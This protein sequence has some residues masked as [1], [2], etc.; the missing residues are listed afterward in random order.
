MAGKNQHKKKN[1]I[2]YETDKIILRELAVA[3]IETKKKQHDK[4]LPRNYAT[5]IL[6]KYAP[7]HPWLNKKLIFNNIAAAENIEKSNVSV[8]L[9]NHMIEKLLFPLHPPRSRN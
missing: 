3:D 5:N 2:K 9:H 7:K 8:P 4:K 6:K 1:V